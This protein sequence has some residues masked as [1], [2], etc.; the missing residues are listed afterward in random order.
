MSKQ[1]ELPISR[2]P[3]QDRNFNRGGRSFYF[4]DFDDNVAFLS[5]PMFLFHKNT[6][7][8]LKISSADYAENSHLIGKSGRFQDYMLDFDPQKGSFRRF[9]DKNLS[10]LDKVLRRP[11]IFVKD[12]TAALGMPHVEWKGPSWSRF[13]HAVFNHRPISLITARGHHPDTIKEGIRVWVKQ[14][15]LPKEPNYLSLYPVSH[16]KIQMDLGLG[17]TESIPRLKQAAVRAS[18]EKAFEVYGFNPHHRFGMSDD[19]PQ[20][21]KWIIEEM[22]LLKKKYGEVSFF[23]FQ[24]YQG[25]MIKH[26]VF[27]DHVEDKILNQTQQLSLFED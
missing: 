17:Q 10:I 26:E 16:P 5:T 18:V 15:H 6:Q 13:Y 7:Q 8:E 20:N 21:V 9:R 19:D 2:E 4:F 1:L 25:Q 23:V 14:G 11:Q 22:T 3:E 24:T 12:L 27:A